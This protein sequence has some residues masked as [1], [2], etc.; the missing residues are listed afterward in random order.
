MYVLFVFT[1]NKN[2]IHRNRVIEKKRI[3]DIHNREKKRCII[4]QEDE[5]KQI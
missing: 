3:L 5:T 4:Y 2:T 1:D